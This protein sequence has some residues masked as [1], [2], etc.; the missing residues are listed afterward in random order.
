MW[1][2]PEPAE[3]V[4][5]D[6]GRFLG[7]G[8]SKRKAVYVRE[9]AKAFTEGGVTTEGLEKMTD[10]EVEEVLV[11]IKGIGQWTVH[12]FLM[13]FLNRP[14]LLPTGDLGVKKGMAL[15]FK[16]STSKLPS[17]TEM[18]AWAKPWAPYRSYGAWFMWRLIDLQNQEVADGKKEKKVV[19]KRKVA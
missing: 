8:L 7:C 12:M 5:E 16:N 17:T 9:L 6:E 2:F 4:E 14:D 15:Y 18:E 19:K 3:V 13:F 1:V 10:G 11:K